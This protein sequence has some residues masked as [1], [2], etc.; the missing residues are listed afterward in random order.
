MTTVSVPVSELSELALDWIVAKCWGVEVYN[1][2]GK[3]LLTFAGDNIWRP[4]V[5]WSQGGPIIEREGISLDNRKGE[6]SRAFMGTPVEYSY[7]MFAPEGQ[8]LTAAMRCYVVSRLGSTIEI[9]A[10]LLP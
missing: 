1:D 5:S 4:S 2:Y 8:P 6:P 3:R 10:E 7:S 9:P